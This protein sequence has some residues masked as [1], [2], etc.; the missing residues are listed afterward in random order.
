MFYFF[1]L[2]ISVIFPLLNV[3][4]NAIIIWWSGY[5]IVTFF[6]EDYIFVFGICWFLEII[7][8]LYI[9]NILVGL[10]SLITIYVIW[11]CC[12]IWLLLPFLIYGLLMLPIT[13]K[14]VSC[15]ASSIFCF[16]FGL[17]KTICFHKFLN[18]HYCTWC[19]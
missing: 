10:I 2:N 1:Q 11:V 6:Y 5:F 9:L 4:F 17:M 14:S 19:I 3:Y 16:C 13:W 18:I 7:W 15:L 12:W 8:V